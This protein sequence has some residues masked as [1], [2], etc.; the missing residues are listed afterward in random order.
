MGKFDGYMLI[1]D[2]DGTLVDRNFGIS[3]ENSEAIRYF[4]ENGG[5]MTIA[6]GR[7]PEDIKGYAHR[8]IP[9]TFIIGL[10]GTVV[11]DPETDTDV[12]ALPFSEDDDIISLIEDAIKDF[13][14]EGSLSLCSRYERLK[15]EDDDVRLLRER[16]ASLPKPW[17][18]VV[19]MASDRVM[20][21]WMKYLS[22]RFGDRYNYNRS[23][24]N[25]LEMHI[26]NSGKGEVLPR[27]RRILAEQ[28]RPVHTIV[29]V[30][31][32]ENDISMVRDADIGY[33]VDNADDTVKAVADRFTVHHFDHV[34]AAIVAELEKEIDEAN[35]CA[36]GP[37]E[38]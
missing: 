11:Y 32:F 28:G 7:A 22:D 36:S 35:A 29:C 4:Q 31:D 6:S 37:C 3:D 30:G 14:Y 13:G 20:E 34:A 38:K 27:I 12:I 8:F 25:G 1:S 10:N 5:R 16:S 19:F 18:K 21:P 17:Y 15:L 9:N 33:A 26:K 2:L 23:W 24:G